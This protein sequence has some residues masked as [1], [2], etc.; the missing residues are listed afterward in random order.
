MEPICFKI[1][2]FGAETGVSTDAG[3][4]DFDSLWTKCIARKSSQCRTLAQDASMPVLETSGSS[5]MTC[6]IKPHLAYANVDFDE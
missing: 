5:R 6:R 1:R 4:L 2:Q 3:R